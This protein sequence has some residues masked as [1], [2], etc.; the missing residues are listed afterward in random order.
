[1][2]DHTIQTLADGKMYLSSAFAW[3]LLPLPEHGKAQYAQLFQHNQT[4]SLRQSRLRL[5]LLKLAL[6]KR[7]AHGRL[8]RHAHED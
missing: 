5:V 8:M 1:M 4:R 2:E 6:A 7:T 3:L